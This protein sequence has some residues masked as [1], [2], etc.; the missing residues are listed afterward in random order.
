MKC[1][2]HEGR[3]GGK[4]ALF[5]HFVGGL[6]KLKYPEVSIYFKRIR[7]FWKSSLKNDKK[8]MSIYIAFTCPYSRDIRFIKSTLQDILPHPTQSTSKQESQMERFICSRSRPFVINVMWRVAWSLLSGKHWYEAPQVP[9][10]GS[11][12]WLCAIGKEV[13]VVKLHCLNQLQRI[14]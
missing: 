1:H 9:D 5:G 10:P 14:V 12:A 2:T 4:G 11:P 6:V 3:N 8:W 7:N 13:G